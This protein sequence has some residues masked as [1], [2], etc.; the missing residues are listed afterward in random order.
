MLEDRCSIGLEGVDTGLI[1]VDTGL[2]V[3]SLWKETTVWKRGFKLVWTNIGV[4]GV[5]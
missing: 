3:E 5:G 4:R 1:G 2:I